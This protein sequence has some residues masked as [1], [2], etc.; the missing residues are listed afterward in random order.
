MQY[1][2]FSDSLNKAIYKNYNSF[3]K[4]HA[5][6]Q[7][8]YLRSCHKTFQ[9]DLQSILILTILVKRVIAA[10]LDT[11]NFFVLFVLPKI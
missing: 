4:N 2:K 10:D 3:N 7:V 9:C 8:N 11:F 6:E 5:N 1:D